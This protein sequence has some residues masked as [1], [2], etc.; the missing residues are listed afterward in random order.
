MLYVK[1][2]LE[3]LKLLFSFAIVFVFTKIG[4]IPTKFKTV[5]TPLVHL[6]PYAEFGDTIIR[7][8]TTKTLFKNATIWTAE[9]EGVISN[10]DIMI[11]NN[12][13]I[14]KIGRGNDATWTIVKAEVNMDV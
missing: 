14:V 5:N 13:K 11:D 10:S 4:L 7:K 1:L 9:S 8:N 12:G 2:E 3:F 6:Y